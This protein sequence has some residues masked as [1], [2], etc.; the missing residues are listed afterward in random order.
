MI[1]LESIRGFYPEELRAGQ[2][3]KHILKEYVE[4]LA[5]E[6]IARSQWAPKLSFIGGT[7]LRLVLGI[8]RF[9]EDLDFDCKGLSQDEFMRFT[10]A[11][12]AYLRLNG[13]NAI[14]KEKESERLTAMRRSI[15]FPGLLHDGGLSAFKEER[16]MMKIE[17]QDQGREY[18]RVFANVRCC[19]FFFPV[20][21]PGEATLCAMKI[22]ALL[23]RG[24]GR[25]FYDTVF[26]LQRT[27]PDYSFF[28]PS[29]PD[30][31]DLQSLKK[32]LSEKVRSVNLELKRRDVEHLLFRHERSDI[33]TRFQ[34]F[35]DSI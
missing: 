19:G 27:E 12:V 17:A 13:L 35:I 34:S 23:A 33:V 18:A 11:L 15:L 2:F 6:W 22:S 25:D 5:L 9:S 29:H 24:K 30:I 26:L 21:V 20:N 4:C 1:S 16:F 14:V 32:A 31:T 3:S 7:N 10:D 28:L 8:D